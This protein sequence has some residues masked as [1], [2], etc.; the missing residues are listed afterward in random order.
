MYFKIAVIICICIIILL[1]P[2]A[3]NA[4]EVKQS[5]SF[6]GG[7]APELGGSCYSYLQDNTFGTPNVIDNY[8][9]G[10][11][12]INKLKTGYNTSNVSKLVGLTS[13]ISWKLIV[14]EFFAFKVSANYFNSVWGGKGTVVFND[15]TNDR[16]LKCEYAIEG[17][18]IP[19]TA[20][21]SIPFYNAIRI[22]LTGGFAY[23]HG[24]YKN[25]FESES[26][27]IYKGRFKGNAFPLVVNCEGE[28]FVNNSFAIMSSLSYYHGKTK[29]IKD[30]KQSDLNTDYAPIDFSG[31]RYVIGISYYF[32]NK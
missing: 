28:Y 18:D 16:E 21:I 17:F 29:S 22:S 4:M 23:A 31:Y 12:G 7:I 13:G 24:T 30:Y 3:I 1:S 9:N 6:Y 26:L 27:F 5:I 2:F 25:R 11:N 10:I 20:G 19:V 14:Y 8:P 32:N 15:G